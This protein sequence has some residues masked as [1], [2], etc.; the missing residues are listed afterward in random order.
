MSAANEEARRLASDAEYALREYISGDAP[1][2]RDDVDDLPPSCL[3]D[4]GIGG[5]L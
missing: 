2:F 3:V 1:L 5:C 4:S